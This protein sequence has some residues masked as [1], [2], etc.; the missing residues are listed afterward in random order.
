[1][2]FMAETYITGEGNSG[3]GGIGIG[4]SGYSGTGKYGGSRGANTWYNSGF[5]GGSNGGPSHTG[6]GGEYGVTPPSYTGNFTPTPDVIT[7][8]V[9]TELPIYTIS[10]FSEAVTYSEAQKEPGIVSSPLFDPVTF[11]AGGIGVTI[12]KSLTTKSAGYVF[13]QGEAGYNAAKDYSF[14]TGAKILEISDDALVGMTI[15]QSAEYLKSASISFAKEAAG[16]T[17]RI[18]VSDLTGVEIERNLFRYELPRLLHNSK[19]ELIWMKV[20]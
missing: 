6:Y 18:F 13:W 11:F 14:K 10:S 16:K 2:F 8:P 15:R 20:P 7:L 17:A 5:S 9:K 4:R 12:Y 1:M 19:T 3:S